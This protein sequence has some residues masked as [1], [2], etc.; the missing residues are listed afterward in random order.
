MVSK[1]VEAKEVENQTKVHQ[2]T[3][4]VKMRID[5][6]RLAEIR[7]NPMVMP[8]PRPH[9]MVRVNP[10]VIAAVTPM[11]VVLPGLIVAFDKRVVV[12]TRCCVI[13]VHCDTC[14][15]GMHVVVARVVVISRLHFESLGRAMPPA[16]GGTAFVVADTVTG[17]DPKLTGTDSG[18][19][20]GTATVATTDAVGCGSQ[21]ALFAA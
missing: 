14:G 20:M 17:S 1:V 4:W 9:H 7:V 21:E 10:M 11:V 15:A 3:D 12:T 16:T 13:H 19:A 8:V 5:N 18:A 6:V 2:D